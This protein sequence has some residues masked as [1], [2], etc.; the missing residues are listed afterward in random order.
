MS[1]SPLR[2][3]PQGRHIARSSR[4]N[5][6]HAVPRLY[7]APVQRQTLATTFVRIHRLNR[8][9][10][11]Q[12]ASVTGPYGTV[13]SNSCPH[14]LPM[15]FVRTSTGCCGQDAWPPGPH[16]TV[17]CRH[18]VPGMAASAAREAYE[19]RKQPVMKPVYGAINA[20]QGAREMVL[21]RGSQLT[22]PSIFTPMLRH[23]PST[24][25]L[26]KRVW[27]TRPLHRV[28]WMVQRQQF[29]KRRRQ[30]PVMTAARPISPKRHLNILR[31]IYVAFQRTLCTSN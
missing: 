5:Y 19:L 15:P 25:A 18:L 21:L 29:V 23:S 1:E 10:V 11:H 17:L 6:D 2:S 14:G 7:V 27:R 24:C 8:H 4:S 30:H 31:S 3:E 28:Y 26:S 13:R 20:Q 16:A 22:S 9:G 12:L